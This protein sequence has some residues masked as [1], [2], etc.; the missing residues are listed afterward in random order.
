[1]WFLQ[2][3]LPGNKAVPL[4][5]QTGIRVWGIETLCIHLCF[6]ATQEP[7]FQG[8][9]REF[10]CL[11]K[12]LRSGTSQGK[13]GNDFRIKESEVHGLREAHIDLRKWRGK[14]MKNSF[15]FH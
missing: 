1:M 4:T 2:V 12:F 8:H 6:S 7:N 5:D 9:V 15:E 11:Q 13:K 10:N 3:Q 14:C